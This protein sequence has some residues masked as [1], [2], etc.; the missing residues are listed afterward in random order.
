MNSTTDITL[1]RSWQFDVQDNISIEDV[2]TAFFD[3]IHAIDAPFFMQDDYLDAKKELGIEELPCFYIGSTASY[4]YMKIC[5][6]VAN[7][8]NHKMVLMGT[9]GKGEQAGPA[10]MEKMFK[11]F[12]GIWI[13]TFDRI[14]NFGEA[15]N[16]AKKRY[17]LGGA[18][19][20]TSVV[21]GKLVGGGIKTAVKGVKIL[22]RDHEAY[23]K[24]MEFYKSVI[25]LSDYLLTGEHSV[26]Y[27]DK[28]KISAESGKVVAQYLLATCYCDGHGTE[29]NKN[30][31]IKWYEKAAE[32]G[33]KR[34][35]EILAYEFLFGDEDY[36]SH[37]RRTGI[38]YLMELVYA[39]DNAAI[40][41]MIGICKD[42]NI[43]GLTITAKNRIE[44]LE[45]AAQ[46]GYI[47]AI[48]CLADI[49][50]SSVATDASLN[51]Y[52][53][54]SNALRMYNLLANAGEY[55]EKATMILGEMYK[56]GRGTAINL[57]LACDNYERASR[58]G[59]IDAKVFLLE[60]YTEND[61]LY[62]L[63][64]IDKLCKEI[65]KKGGKN[66]QHFVLYYKYFIADAKKEYKK[67][68]EYAEK[69][70]ANEQGD[71]EKKKQLQRYL[72]EQNELINKMSEE[73]R[74][75]YLKER[76]PLDPKVKKYIL[77]GI[78]AVLAI[79]VIVFGIKA[80]SSNVEPKGSNWDLTE[81]GEAALAAYN[82]WLS[83]EEIDVGR[84][85]DGAGG[86]VPELWNSDNTMFN[87]AYIDE[88]DVPELIL[89]NDTDT[90]HETGNGKIVCYR[91]GEVSYYN[92]FSIDDYDDCFDEVIG[93]YEM[94]GYFT[95]YNN[96]QG[97]VSY[98]T[99]LGGQ[100]LQDSFLMS[101]VI[102]EDGNQSEISYSI[103]GMECSD[104]DYYDSLKE[105]TFGL[106]ITPYEFYDNTE[107]NRSSLLGEVLD[108]Q[109][110]NKK[111]D[112]YGSAFGF[113]GKTYGDIEKD[114]GPLEQNA[115]WEGVVYYQTNDKRWVGFPLYQGW[116]EGEEC[117]S[118]TKCIAYEADKAHIKEI[119]N[120][121]KN[122]SI[123]ELADALGVPFDSEGLVYE[124]YSEF[125]NVFWE[126]KYNNIN[127]KLIAEY[128]E[129]LEIS[130][131]TLCFA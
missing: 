66:Y 77:I 86:H 7:I 79:I 4:K 22:L 100:S 106:E 81:E 26:K 32:N 11:D 23:A 54:D 25:D 119:F 97:Y 20:G 29:A 76:K 67:S 126:I 57:Q 38:N 99:S 71:L 75:E 30:I 48:L 49:Y 10:E 35:R 113:L 127:Y 95:S 129:N 73:E 114:Y 59:N 109:K 108:E 50:D 12:K 39:G 80:I 6:T 84:N 122:T 120:I 24:E 34:S 90:T 52:K 51:E 31:G 53:N 9:F 65:Q 27:F 82:N 104:T 91:D 5:V 110:Q 63:D 74:R 2:R 1:V 116:N 47:S 41:S 45:N 17:K 103:D 92:S 105:N 36:D 19:A 102:D 121:E 46:N 128:D 83:Q 115:G 72:N 87:V 56:N 69:Y 43:K 15:V 111:D 124:D 89:Y 55:T 40:E 78:G 70:I 96:W 16:Y 117:P 101:Y 33:E 85:E 14:H 93:Y 58:F 68:M 98:I 123:Q 3:I 125:N 64:K 61:K 118:D 42:N 13:N 21:V 62:D 130:F 131:L 44:F 112:I 94:T 60:L 18:A 88:D 28:L 107:D 37:N 8:E